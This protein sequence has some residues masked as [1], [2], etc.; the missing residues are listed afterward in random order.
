MYLLT[1]KQTFQRGN[2]INM[3]GKV[4]NFELGGE[5]NLLGGSFFY[6]GGAMFQRDRYWGVFEVYNFLMVLALAKDHGKKK[7]FN[8]HR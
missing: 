4:F 3:T 7:V 8:S 1:G 6:F 2:N 5:A